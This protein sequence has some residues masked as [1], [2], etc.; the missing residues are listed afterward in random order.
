MFAPPAEILPQSVLA[1]A[2]DPT[3][4][5]DEEETR[6]REVGER[7]RRR[8]LAGLCEQ[9]RWAVSPVCRDRRFGL[10]G[11]VV[12]SRRLLVVVRL[13]CASCR[14]RGVLLATCVFACC[15]RVVAPSS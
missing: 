12:L 3:V 15:V 7:V 1:K 14:R 2:G 5:V 10:C 11:S 4:R 6:S 9:D 13:V 8:R